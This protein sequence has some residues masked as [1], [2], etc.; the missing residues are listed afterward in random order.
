MTY[1]YAFNLCPDGIGIIS[2]TRLSW[3]TK[4]GDVGYDD[5]AYQKIYCPA[6]NTFIAVAGDT[7][8]L[9]ALLEG[10]GDRLSNTD[11]RLRFNCFQ[12][13]S[14][15]KYGELWASGYFT[16]Q[17]LPCIALLY[18]DIRR[19]RGKIK[20]RLLRHEFGTRNLKP[21]IFHKTY[22]EAKKST[23]IGWSKE[24]RKKLNN[25]AVEAMAELDSRSLTISPP[26]QSILE[27]FIQNHGPIPQNA[28]VYF[29]STKGK[30]DSS[31]RA[32]LRKHVNSAMA[33]QPHLMRYDP[34]LIFAGAAQ[35]AIEMR[36]ND[37]RK[38][39]LEMHETVADTWTIAT[40]TMKDGFRVFSDAE[41][42]GIKN[43]YE[44]MI[45]Q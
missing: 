45:R 34:V 42:A 38:E 41:L 28:S 27:K 37:L 8:Q 17:N 2:D 14:K 13:F 22:N 26:S 12:D 35:K 21:A 25:A 15:E 4:F 32:I 5:T 44:S 18:G 11:Q 1:S 19:H 16:A 7:E 30:R 24:G 10:V 43:I 40:L 29:M 3:V 39:M 36:M 33:E 9:S 6:P 31:F 23:A 20:C